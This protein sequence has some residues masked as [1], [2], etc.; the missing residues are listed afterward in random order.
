MLQRIKQFLSNIRLKRLLL[1]SFLTLLAALLALVT[2]IAALPAVLSTTTAQSYLRSSLTKTLKRQV[3]WSALNLSWSKGLDLKGLALGDGPAPLLKLSMEKLTMAP[4][5]SYR[6]GRVRVDL[7]LLISR[8]SVDAAPGPAKPPK[9]YQEPLTAIAEAVQ[10]FQGLD[11]PLPL[12]LGV[13]VALQPARLSYTDPGSGRNLQLDNLAFS[14]DMPSLADKPIVIDLKSDLAVDNHPLE[15]LSF[16]ADLQRLVTASRRIHP[17]GALVRIKGSLPGISLSLK[18]GLQEPEGFSARASLLLPRIMAT[19]GP[20][21]PKSLPIVKG[22]VELDLVARFDEAQNLHA[23]MELDGS[24]IALSGGRLKGPVGPLDLKVRQKIVSDRQKQQV[25]FSEGGAKIDKLLEAGWEA[26]VDRPSSKDR[27]LTAMLGPVRVELQQALTVAGPLLGPRFPVR[28]LAGELTLQQLLIKLKGRDGSGE[29]TLAGLGISAPRLRLAL[30]KGEVVGD[31]VD[32]SIDSLTAPLEAKQPVRVD[33]AISYGLQRCTLKGAKPVVAE[34]L[35]GKL[36]LAV[37]DLNLKSRSPRKVS[38]NL[39]VTQSLD[40]SRVRLEQKLSAESLHEQLTA[41]ISAKESG[42]IEVTL[43]ELKVTAGGLQTTAG[44]KQLKSLPLSTVVTAGSIRLAAAKGALPVVEAADCKVTGGDFLQLSARGSLPAGSPQVAATD[45]TLRVDMEKALPFAAP[46]L[47]KGAAAT[48]IT[49]VTWSLAAPV[50][51]QSL[52]VGKNPLVK[53]RAALGM[54]ERAEVTLS[55]DN[56]AISWPLKSGSLAI[57]GLHTSRPLRVS[58]PVKGGKITVGGVV[59]FAGLGGLSRGAV[60]LPPQSGSF[61]LQGELSDWQSLKLH[62]ELTARPFG[63]AQKADVAVSRIDRLLEK[64]ETISAAS[65]LQQLDGVVTTDL[66]AR[67]PPQ[68]T[69]VPGGVELSGESRAQAAI[70]L[71]GGRELRL[72]G[73]AALRDFGA[74]LANG[75]IVEGVHADLLIDRTYALSKGGAVA[76]SPLSVSLV[77]PAPEHFAAAGGAEIAGRVRED[78]RGQESGSRKFTIR[79]LVTRSGETPLELTSLEG[80]LLL[81]SEETGLSFFQSEIL[82]GT[83]RLRSMIDLKPDVPTVAAACSFT[84]LETVLLLPAEI[85]KKQ[86]GFEPETAITGEV[87]LDAPLQTGQRELLEGLRMRL[88]LRKIGANTLERALF[89]LDPNERNEQVVKLRKQLRYGNLQVLRA[90]TLDGAF[91]LEGEVNVKGVTIAL[92]KVERLRLSELP[93][94][95]QMAKA[96]A[97]IASLRKLLDLAR[98]D[99]LVVGPGGKISLVRLGAIETKAK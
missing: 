81:G 39:R 91:G 84:N 22:G 94:K 88:N 30:A 79:R 77:R 60:K 2:L 83:V 12:D 29:V 48:G 98:A 90:S 87:S 34:G 38:A 56:R 45:G 76:W 63:L 62:Q 69:P 73:T 10:K 13:K 80:D 61:S 78:L 19:Y 55:L 85:R 95:K 71:V 8:L 51:K 6:Q 14:F 58:V 3:T 7:S 66:E 65:L 17:A 40:L 72:R 89:G 92:P 70:N 31:G 86:S 74:R 64:Q 93:I 67:F 23:S 46:F 9:P 20:L 11:W 1:I 21:L 32:L 59:D 5:I 50:L 99:T 33:A 15:S 43:P 75:T 37:T 96:L 44:G 57:S 47:P 25:R 41:L 27:E 28:E 49:S 68:P 97:G 26:T 16:S 18:G 52:P 54:V 24:E 42:E 53:A 4:E 36:Q 35:R 82:G